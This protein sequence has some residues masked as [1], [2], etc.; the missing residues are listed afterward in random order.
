[1]K[2]DL[3]KNC[4]ERLAKDWTSPIYVFFKPVPI[5]EYV[6]ER[7]I[8]VFECAA[9]QC[10]GKG[11]G[12]KVDTG[13][14]KSTGNLHKHAKICWGGE[15][16]AAATSTRDVRSAREALVKLKSVDASITVEELQKIK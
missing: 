8:H 11:N 2:V 13:D 9:V 4:I 10:M 16:V 14:A 3:A 15:A 12:W 7:R 5:I 1:M 6:K